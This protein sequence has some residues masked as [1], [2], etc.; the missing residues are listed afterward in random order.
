M[1]PAE[2]PPRLPDMGD[3]GEKLHNLPK[4]GWLERLRRWSERERGGDA[5]KGGDKSQLGGIIATGGEDTPEELVYFFSVPVG[6]AAFDQALWELTGDAM[7]HQRQLNAL[8]DPKSVYPPPLRIGPQMT[9]DSK[10]WAADPRKYL[11]EGHP[12]RPERLNS[13]DDPGYMRALDS[14]I[15][16]GIPGRGHR[17]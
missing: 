8:G 9:Q 14:M 6:R 4:V 13:Y 5:M 11:P 3:V 15:A 17:Q 7:E 10:I 16:R 12:A 1:E 2:H